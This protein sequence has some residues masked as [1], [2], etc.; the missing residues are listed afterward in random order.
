MNKEHPNISMIK[1]FNPAQPNTLAEV[2]AENF[3]WHYIN[4]EL[5]EL[6]GDYFGLSGLTDFFQMHQLYAPTM[7]AFVPPQ[8]GGSSS[9]PSA[10]RSLSFTPNEG[11]SE[12]GKITTL[13]TANRS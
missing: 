3:V 9:E 7:E 8:R 13:Q 5:S 4:P 10:S 2:L 11:H 12:E 6:E 1:R